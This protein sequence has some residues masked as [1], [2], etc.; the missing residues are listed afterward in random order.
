MTPATPLPHTAFALKIARHYH[1]RLPAGVS[2]ADVEQAALIGLWDALRRHK[3]ADYSPE[4]WR[5]YLRRRIRGSIADEL[6]RQDWAHRRRK[7]KTDH[8]T[9]IRFDDIETAG[10]PFVDTIRSREPSPED[11]AVTR[12]DSA[13]ALRA[14]VNPIDRSALDQVLM[15]GR[16]QWDV[17]KDL[18]MSEPRVSQ[19]LHRALRVMRAW[20]DGKVEHDD[21]KDP[22]S[23]P[24]HTHIA[25]LEE[26]E[27][28]KHRRSDR[29][30]G[31]D[32]RRAAAQKAE[33]RAVRGARLGGPLAAHADRQVPRGAGAAE[34]PS[35]PRSGVCTA[36]GRRPTVT[37][38]QKALVVRNAERA[39]VNLKRAVALLRAEG[40]DVLD[41]AT[42]LDLDPSLVRSVLT[43]PAPLRKCQR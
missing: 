6:R 24:L 42:R 20:L 3:A 31:N 17:A 41:I 14:P 35:A 30:V 43:T 18:G 1:R 40:Y 34:L 12:H 22:T 25:I 37:N 10:A 19:R 7:H 33:P 16:R 11:E 8:A 21:R 32:P 13:Y 28:R 23:V 36:R 5:A 39:A 2:W 15:R 27:H 38:E 4:Q 29:A 9:I 26:H